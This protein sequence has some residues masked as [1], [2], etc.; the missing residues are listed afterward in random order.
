VPG[1]ETGRRAWKP[2]GPG[3]GRGSTG[4]EETGRVRRAYRA[5]PGAPGARCVEPCAAATPIAVCRL[6]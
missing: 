3:A 1:V 5:E 2:G 6:C 4:R